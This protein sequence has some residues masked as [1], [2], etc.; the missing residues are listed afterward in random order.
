MAHEVEEAF[1]LA[2]L[3]AEMHVGDKERTEATRFTGRHS[4]IFRQF[5]CA[6]LLQMHMSLG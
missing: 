6:A 2:S 5:P 3:G 4:V 1:G